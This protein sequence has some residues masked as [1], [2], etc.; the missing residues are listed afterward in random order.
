MKTPRWRM[1]ATIAW[2]SVA[3][4]GS[5][6]ASEV[7][8]LRGEFIRPPE[9]LHNHGSCLVEAPNGDLIVCWFNGSGER[10]ADDCRILGAR[11]VRGATTWSP[12]FVMAD[13]P[14]FPDTNCCLF[15]DPQQRLWLIWPTILDNHWESALLKVKIAESYQRPGAPEWK[16][17]DV[18]HVKP[19]PEFAATVQRAVEKFR[20][21]A[22]EPKIKEFVDYAL[23]ASQD[24][25]KSRL[26]WMTRAH[27]FVLD[28][29]RLIV[30]LYSDGFNFSL[31][32][33]TDDWG[34]TW[35]TSTPLVGEGNV[36][37][38]IVR[39]RD[40]S[41]YTMMR[42]N[43]L[44]P[45]RIQ[46]ASSKDRGETWTDVT[47]SDLPDPG[48]GLEIIAL[49]NGH[50]VVINNDTE[51]GRHSLCVRL[52]DDEGRTWKW[53]RHLERDEPGADAG[54][55][56]YPS[57]LQAKDGTLHATYSVQLRPS[58]AAK[59]AEGKPAHKTIR[60]VHFN[61]AWIRAGNR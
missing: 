36:Q 28:G 48:A 43:G 32:A 47:D 7:P 60:H 16:T 25:L 27:P 53:S 22:G 23:A 40:G 59:D 24:K 54:R 21:R 2:C 11:L 4:L 46:Q 50:W 51:Q 52:S 5:A 10:T 55:Y 41:L 44:P 18:I 35:H 57:I 13:T 3:W 1:L 26:G 34:A 45:Q 15:I 17:Q 12:R 58:L 33:I 8:F 14:G 19:G 6:V 42:D 37:P 31:M 39:R 9:N 29:R 61:E 20:A 38:S 56:G 30:P 49:A